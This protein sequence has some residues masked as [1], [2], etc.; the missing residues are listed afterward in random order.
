M[1]T[2]LLGLKFYFFRFFFVVNSVE[3]IVL[4]WKGK[5]VVAGAARGFIDGIWL[6][7]P[8][9]KKLRLY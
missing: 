4:G 6:P 9:F 1:I 5:F 7:G 2:V 8:Q 3:Y